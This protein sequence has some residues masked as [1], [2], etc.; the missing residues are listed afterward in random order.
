M[1]HNRDNYRESLVINECEK[2]LNL[3]K[4]IDTIISILYQKYNESIYYPNSELINNNDSN[5]T[6]IMNLPRF[7][8]IELIDSR[9]GVEYSELSTGE[10]SL[11]DVVYSIKNIIELRIKNNLSNSIFILLDEIES[12]LHPI[13][14]KNLIQY[15]YNFVK[16]YSIDI[17]IILTSHSPFILSDI[18]KENVIFLEKYKKDEDKNQKEGNCKNATKDIELKTFGANIHTLLSNGF[19]MS[20]GLMGEFAKSKIEEIKKFYELVKF[21]EPKNKKYKR[22]LKILY[23]F[24]IKKFN[25]IQSIIGEPFLQTIIKNYLDELEQIFDNETYKKNKMKEFLDQFEP[26]E[27]QKYLDE[28][29]AKA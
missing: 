16:I 3:F 11:L 1:N 27:L 6:L 29:N 7:L 20:D 18:P 12:Y 9:T 21:L 22:I 23:L 24:K 17:H 10:K 28:K 19:F 2:S 4:N 26:E 13:W 5:I 15:I 25:H 14:Q 8:K